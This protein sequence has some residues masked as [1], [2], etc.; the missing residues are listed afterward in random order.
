M[1]PVYTTLRVFQSPSGIFLSNTAGD[2]SIASHLNQENSCLSAFFWDRINSLTQLILSFHP[3]SPLVHRVH[4]V[5]QSLQALF[6]MTSQVN[7]FFYSPVKTFLEKEKTNPEFLIDLYK[8]LLK[9]VQSEL[10]EDQQKIQSILGRPFSEQDKEQATTFLKSFFSSTQLSIEMVQNHLREMNHS[11]D[12]ALPPQASLSPFE[13]PHSQETLSNVEKKW[14]CYRSMEELTKSFQGFI[15]LFPK[16]IHFFHSKAFQSLIKVSYLL[17]LAY[18]GFLGLFSNKALSLLPFVFLGETA[19]FLAQKKLLPESVVSLFE[20]LF[21]L[22]LVLGSSFSP[23]GIFLSCLSILSFYVKTS[24]SVS[25]DEASF[26]RQL[27]DLSCEVLSA[28]EGL[29]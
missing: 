23:S 14:L 13:N 7:L 25:S 8:D 20:T 3:S 24:R 1:G 18:F 16:A 26:P 19:L 2:V 4:V 6:Y 10:S 11:N 5:S 9:G 29:Y 12:S 28:L 27:I 17:S 22:S 15:D 21:Y